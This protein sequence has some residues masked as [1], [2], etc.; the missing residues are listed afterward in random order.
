MLVSSLLFM[1]LST[2]LAAET[3][4]DY[5]YVDENR[6]IGKIS[7]YDVRDITGEE[8]IKITIPG[9]IAQTVKPVSVSDT[10][11]EA[12]I[13]IQK[14]NQVIADLGLAISFGTSFEQNK[15]LLSEASYRAA[16]TYL[17]ETCFEK[18]SGFLIIKNNLDITARGYCLTP[19]PKVN[20]RRGH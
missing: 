12:D 4:V 3:T 18:D 19:K 17:P 15:S 11:L 14:G 5:T 2:S 13:L 1:A 20:R 6:A 10:D 16:F 8:N 7:I 9:Y